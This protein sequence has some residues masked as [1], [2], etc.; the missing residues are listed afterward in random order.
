VTA[1][2][3][4]E[5][6]Q[7][8]LRLDAEDIPLKIDFGI[9]FGLLVNELLCNSLKHAFP[10]GRRGIISVF[11]DRADGAVQLTVRD[12]GRGLPE[13]FDLAACSSMGLKL[14]SSLARQLGGTLRFS[15]DNGC[16][17]DAALT[18]M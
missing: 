9:P 5:P 2:N 14:A 10:G 11:V 6:G 7:I 17:V 4:I 12:D 16:R 15:N 3:S 18:R 13:N 8:Q 1:S